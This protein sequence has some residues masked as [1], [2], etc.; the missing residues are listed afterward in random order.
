MS[1]IGFIS[2]GG[3]WLMLEEDVGVCVCLC[4]STRVFV[5]VEVCVFADHACECVDSCACM[6]NTCAQPIS[7]YKCVRVCICMSV[8]VH[9]A[10]CSCKCTDI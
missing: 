9:V 7:P 8:H 1:S 5:C 4:V 6:T 2:K 10:R 3:L